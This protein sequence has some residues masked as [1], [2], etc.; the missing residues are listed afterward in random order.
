MYTI[1]LIHFRS[2]FL[3]PFLPSL[4]VSK[5]D[6]STQIGGAMFGRHLL[7]STINLIGRGVAIALWGAF[8]GDKVGHVHRSYLLHVFVL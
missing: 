1:V 7:S 3:F 2:F 5:M 6:G 8:I 4:D